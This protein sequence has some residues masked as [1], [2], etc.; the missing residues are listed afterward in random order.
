MR[1]DVSSKV[2]DHNM[3]IRIYE[4]Y[5]A[6]CHMPEL[7][8]TSFTLFDLSISKRHHEFGNLFSK[9]VFFCDLQSLAGK[10]SGYKPQRD[11]IGL[12]AN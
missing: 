11:G 9:C 8:Q 5:G 6:F 4:F 10:P 2:E 7:C 3:V 1:G 12:I